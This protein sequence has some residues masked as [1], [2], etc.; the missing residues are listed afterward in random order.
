MVKKLRKQFVWVTNILM[1]TVFGGFLVINTLYNVYWNE[2][3][4]LG[5]LEWIAHSGIFLTSGESIQERNVVLELLDEDRPIIGII[6][7]SNNEIIS[8]QV[9]GKEKS[10]EGYFQIDKIIIDKMCSSGIGKYKI[11]KYYYSYNRIDEERC[12][13]VVMD[14]RLPGPL[15]LWWVGVIALVGVG[16]CALVGITFFL[17]RFVTKPAEQSLLREKTF[18]SDASHELKTP[19]GAICINAQA[20]EIDMG[21][22][23]YINNIVSESQRMGRLIEKLLILSKLDEEES[24]DAAYFSLS[25]VCYEMALTYEST[26]Y[27]K[28]LHFEYAI[29][30]NLFIYGNEDEIRQLIAIL[31]DNALKNTENDGKILL[32]CYAENNKKKL[33]I[34]NTGKGIAQEDI[35]HVFERFY[36]TDKARRNGSFGLGLAI[37]KS[38]VVRH[39][40]DIRVKS[41]INEKTEFVVIL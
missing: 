27:E 20:L 36:T 7:N 25:D 32:S 3:E 33:T 24:V 8:K 17:S 13:L 23:V 38:I 5:M 31:I 39:G 41:E 37:A 11:G 40:G 4:M 21:D 18:I 1:I 35:P 15:I 2:R 28:Q 9:L 16:F 29:E 14:D 12:L 19:L 10:D 30:P 26:A 34:L 6:L 22:N